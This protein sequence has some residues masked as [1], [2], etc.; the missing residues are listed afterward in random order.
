[1]GGRT[2]EGGE[3]SYIYNPDSRKWRRGPDLPREIVWGCAFNL[4]GGLYI[5]GGQGGRC[6]NNRTF[7]LR[8]ERPQ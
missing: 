3:V 6:Y 1:M 7:R 5:T 4:D 8:E 2:R